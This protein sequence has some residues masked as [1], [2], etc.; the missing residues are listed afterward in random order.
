MESRIIGN[1]EKKDETMTEQG[2]REMV[3]GEGVYLGKTEQMVKTGKRKPQPLA[4]FCA[5]VYLSIPPT[6]REMAR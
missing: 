4:I 2:E 1:A 5:H 6:A 3:D